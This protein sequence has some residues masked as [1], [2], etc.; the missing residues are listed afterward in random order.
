MRSRLVLYSLAG[1]LVLVGCLDRKKK[2]V[3]DAAEPSSDAASS[4][5]DATVTVEAFARDGATA[6][7]AHVPSD[8][9]FRD[10]ADV[11]LTGTGGAGGA[12]VG[13][14]PGAGGIPGL[15]GSG[16]PVGG[17]PGSGGLI[18]SAGITSGGGALASGGVVLK[19]GTV[20]SGGLVAASG[21]TVATGGVV[22]TGGSRGS[23]GATCQPKSRDCTSSLD[24]DCNGTTDNQE[25]SFCTCPVGQNRACEEHLGYDGKGICTAG[26]QICGASTDKTTSSWGGCSGSIPPGTRN[27]TS[28]TDNDCNGT[29]DSQE[30]AYC[31]CPSGQT[32]SCLPAGMCTA[33]SQTCAVSS[34]R[35]TTAWG[36]CTGYTGPTP[37]YR[38]S[39]GDGYGS[40]SQSAQVCP[41]T[42][43]YVS[44][45]DDCDDSDPGFKP[46]ASVCP[47][48][49]QRKSCP[50]SGGVTKLESC[51]Q[52]CLNGACRPVSDGTV[53]LP[54][55]VS[56]NS[57][58]RCPTSQGCTWG[59]TSCG[60]LDSPGTGRCDGPN[61]CPGETCCVYYGRGGIT[62]QC[63]S[64]E[65]PSEYSPACDPLVGA[66]GCSCSV[67]VSDYPIYTCQ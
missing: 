13:G 54:G 35:S 15:G 58:K 8:L 14:T 16:G 39:D 25:A 3:S 12:S 24:N 62:S 45:A 30:T 42:S 19:G 65:C 59:S 60:T 36:P 43:G 66:S 29:A 57:A 61:D 56:C 33:G 47:D 10:T 37:M 28:G 32:K 53:G 52:G 46:G 48:A 67:L 63:A 41:G 31:Q 27:C 26:K 1:A 49:T 9:L 44:N 5:Y 17:S 18:G 11:L 2:V 51:D 20:G 4:G 23:G 50:A 21:G 55:Y 64:G 22:A 7:A 38:D 34:D 40:P 6:E